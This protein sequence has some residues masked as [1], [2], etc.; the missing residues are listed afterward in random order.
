MRKSRRSS[1]RPH[2]KKHNNIK[3]YHEAYSLR[4]DDRILL[5][6]EQSPSTR[7]HSTQKIDSSAFTG[8]R[9]STHRSSGKTASISKKI[10]ATPDASLPAAA[11]TFLA[12]E[13]RQE[14]TTST[15]RNKVASRFYLQRERD[16]SFEQIRRKRVRFFGRVS[17]LLVRFRAQW[18]IFSLSSNKP[19]HFICFRFV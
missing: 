7:M 1:S 2:K 16:L 14:E 8:S 4:F 5:A 13:T 15:T 17:R 10:R 3:K 6:N 12:R 19:P 9:L 18:F 11:E